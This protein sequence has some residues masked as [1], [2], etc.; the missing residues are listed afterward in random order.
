MGGRLTIGDLS[1]AP[2]LRSKLAH[3]C[4]GARPAE[5]VGSVEFEDGKRLSLAYNLIHGAEGRA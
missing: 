3:V 5:R 1:P 2:L 4:G